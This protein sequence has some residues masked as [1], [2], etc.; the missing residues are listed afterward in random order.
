[1]SKPEVSATIAPVRRRDMGG[2]GSMALKFISTESD[3]LGG[4]KEAMRIPFQVLV[5][6]CWLVGRVVI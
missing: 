3:G 2:V 6:C 4:G 5:I 1:M